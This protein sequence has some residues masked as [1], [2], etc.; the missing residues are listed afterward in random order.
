MKSCVEQK[1]ILNNILLIF[2]FALTTSCF[3]QLKKE[4]T[5]NVIT[6]AAGGDWDDHWGPEGATQ[7]SL[8]LASQ[9][10][11]ILMAGDLAYHGKDNQME[12]NIENAKNWSAKANTIAKNTPILFVGGDHD[13]NNQDGDILTYAEHLN[14]PDGTNGVLPPMG[15]I[16]DKTYEGKYPY[17]WYNDVI[18]EDVKVRIIGTSSAFQETECEPTEMQKYLKYTYAKGSENY[19]WIET[20]YADAKQKGYW[21]IHLN[22]LPWIDMGKNQSFVDSQDLIDLAGKYGVNVLITGSSHNIWRTKPLQLNK[23]CPSIALTKNTNGANQACVG[24]QDNHYYKKSDGLIQA[25]AGVSGKTNALKL[26]KYP[27]AC[28]PNAD[29]EVKY[30]AA[31]NTCVTNAITGIVSLSITSNKLT[32]KFVKIDGSEFEPYTFVISK[33]D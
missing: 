30:Y 8:E 14:Y 22:H 3:G 9:H 12:Y 25:H 28:D 10:D 4:Q 33:D 19:Q 16:K 26:I 6:I 27:D 15:N 13:S 1:I 11:L 20:V 17:L 23:D 31:K 5:K 21:M 7:K 2:L 32:G 18:K 29:G 24:N